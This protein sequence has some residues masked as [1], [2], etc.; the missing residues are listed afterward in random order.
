[1]GARPESIRPVDRVS[2]DVVSTERLPSPVREAL[3]RAG[4]EC[5]RRPTVAGPAAP[6]STR[7]TAP[8]L[9]GTR[10]CC[11]LERALDVAAPGTW[12]VLPVRRSAQD[13]DPVLRGFD[14]T[15]GG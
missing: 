8:R 11:P 1:M 7:S 14:R 3:G 2:Y 4:P 13:L 15:N 5:C 6:G 10:R 9:R 12:P